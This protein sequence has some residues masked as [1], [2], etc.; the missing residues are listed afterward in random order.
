M[1]GVSVTVEIDSAAAR[2][3]L[4][5]LS[6]FDLDR[7]AYAVGVLLEEQTKERIANEKR[8]PEGAPW[9]AWSPAYAATRDNRHSLLVGSGNPG[10]LESITNR[11][12]GE[13]ARVGSNLV[14]AAIHQFGGQ[15]GRGLAAT[16]PARPYLGLS[17]A[18]RVEIE[19][20]VMDSLEA[21]L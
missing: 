7:M 6:A 19:E 1:A 11:T 4:S 10:L 9:A 20:L 14:Y 21:I 15:A 12:T 17:A 5:R 16:I 8:S 2:S 18:N 3:A 13:A